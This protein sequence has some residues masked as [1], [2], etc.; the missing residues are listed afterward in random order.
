MGKFVWIIGCISGKTA[1]TKWDLS[2]WL[3]LYSSVGVPPL[4]HF[5]FVSNSGAHFLECTNNVAS[6]PKFDAVGIL[7]IFAAPQ[8]SFISRVQLRWK[9]APRIWNSESLIMLF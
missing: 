6:K 8:N 3:L 5:L 2:S 7:R 9:N 1:C 4:H